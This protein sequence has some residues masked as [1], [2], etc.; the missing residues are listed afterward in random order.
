MSDEI[1]LRREKL[2][3]AIRTLEKMNGSPDL[4]ASCKK[5][6]ESIKDTP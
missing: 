2:L 6:L 3:E 5:A 1:A 4:I